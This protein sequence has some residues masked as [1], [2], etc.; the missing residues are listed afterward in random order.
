MYHSYAKLTGLGSFFKHRAK[1]IMPT[2]LFIVLLC[3]ICGAFITSLS[4]SDYFSNSQFWKYL[5]A[6]L[7]F[8]NWLQ[9]SLPGVFDGDEY[10]LSAVNGSLWTMKVEWALDLSVPLFVWLI[11]KTK[12]RNDYLAIA[13]IV[14]SIV[15]KTGFEYLYANSGKAIYEIMSRQLFGQ[16][17]FFYM[18]MLIYFY[19]DW[20]NL[21]K[22]SIIIISLILYIVGPFIPFG[23]AII[24]P[25]AVPA[26]LL[27]VSMIGRTIKRFEHRNCISYN[28]FLV[29]YPI[30]Q[31]TIFLGLNN[32]PIWMSLGF[33]LITTIALALFTNR[34]ID[35][36]FLRR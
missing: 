4:I 27:S 20:V 8:L 22:R 19:R 13:L 2:Y 5:A 10:T 17:G 24:A 16:M 34:F 11:S 32:Q 35:Q 26:L 3:A 18:G 15:L 12:W 14:I 6:N 7:T 28:I 23:G 29:H 33:I 36:R 21:N 25:I 31:F 1:R 30:I 9:P